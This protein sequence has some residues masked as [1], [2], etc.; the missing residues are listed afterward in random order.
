MLASRNA[1]WVYTT[2]DNPPA[3]PPPGAIVEVGSALVVLVILQ[4]AP[5]RNYQ[6][7]LENKIYSY[8]SWRVHGMLEGHSHTV[9]S[10]VGCVWPG[11]LHL[12]G[13]DE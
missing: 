12:L 9:Q 5:Q 1:C 3:G 13:W 8:R 10:Q 11:A 2:C 7:T 4:E 6:G